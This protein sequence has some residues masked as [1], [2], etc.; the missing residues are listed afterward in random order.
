[1]YP[2]IFNKRFKPDNDTCKY[3]LDASH[4]YLNAV[5]GNDSQLLSRNLSFYEFKNM[6]RDRELAIKD[7]VANLSNKEDQFLATIALDENS[8]ALAEASQYFYNNEKSKIYKVSANFIKALSKIKDTVRYE[9]LP[10]N[11]SGYVPIP[12]GTL[13][14]YEGLNILGI[15]ISLDRFSF[16]DEFIKLCGGVGISYDNVHTLDILDDEIVLGDFNRKK[17]RFV[18]LCESAYRL[19]LEPMGY[20]FSLSDGDTVSGVLGSF[21]KGFSKGFPENPLRP[22]DFCL[23]P[24]PIDPGKNEI[25]L[26]SFV[27]N[28]ISYIHSLEPDVSEFKPAVSLTS[29]QRKIM[30]NE[31]EEVDSSYPTVFVSWSYGKDRNYS[32]DSTW[33]DSHLRWQRCGTGHM[34]T[35][36]IMVTGHERQ[37]NKLEIK[38]T[39][40][41]RV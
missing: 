22:G 32:V 19:G 41:L 20:K 31:Y 21:R 33:V 3:M 4:M 11:F 8:M 15:Y 38:L 14:D 9:L 40:E 39:E 34:D 7:M 13:K 23:N 17:L 30:E 10:D 29:K 18:I 25:E 37:F 2:D 26:S 1:M 35:K 6:L 24:A 12:K 36:L 27:I 28:L 16:S 5:G